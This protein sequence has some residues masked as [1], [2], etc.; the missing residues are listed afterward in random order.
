MKTDHLTK[1][2]LDILKDELALLTSMH[3][4][5]LS[6]LKSSN[7]KDTRVHLMVPLL[8]SI[9]SSSNCLG[10]MLTHGF[11]NEAYMIV[12]A[13]YERCLNYCYLSCCSERDF[14][15]YFQHSMQKNLRALRSELVVAN[16][17]FTIESAHHRDILDMPAV[18]KVVKEYSRKVSGKEV[19]NWSKDTKNRF[20]RLEWISKHV[21]GILWQP[22]VL[23]EVMLFEEASEAL[24]GTFYGSLFHTGY[25]EPRIKRRDKWVAVDHITP[26]IQLLIGYCVLMHNSL[27][28]SAH[29]RLANEEALKRSRANVLKTMEFMK[30][31]SS[32]VSI[33]SAEDMVAF[34]VPKER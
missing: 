16:F 8:G 7:R 14:D 12:R 4:R 31:T 15:S 34:L 3:S 2:L 30:H 9:I 18:D 19:Q 26:Q 25:L 23:I 1:P 28:Q 20:E 5:H 21:N 32:S 29:Q 11:L 6:L 10:M 24:H 17:G 33:N 22:Y 27:I 13:L